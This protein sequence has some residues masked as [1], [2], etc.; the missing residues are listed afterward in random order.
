VAAWINP[1]N[2]LT[3]KK[4]LVKTID[5]RPG[6]GVHPLFLNCGQKKFFWDLMV[7]ANL[8]QRQE[9]LQETPGKSRVKNG[10]PRYSPAGQINPFAT[11]PMTTAACVL[12][13]L[14]SPSASSQAF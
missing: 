2:D 8:V 9:L 3:L 4:I 1:I 10:A 7:F 6:D 12:C 14:V 11:H 5:A 13:W